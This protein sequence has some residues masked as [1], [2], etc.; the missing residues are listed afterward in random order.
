MRGFSPIYVIDDMQIDI[1]EMQLD[2]SEIETVTFV[3]D[4]VGKAMYGPRA[5][6]G[7]IFIKTKKGQANDR[8]LNV[9]VEGGVS[10]VDRFPKWATAGE[11]A[12]LNNRPTNALRRSLE[13]YFSSSL[14][15]ITI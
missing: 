3:K 8:I 12:R 6:N 14:P 15:V 13:G 5:A 4:V 2:P 9:N 7:I 11:Y 1:T 10:T